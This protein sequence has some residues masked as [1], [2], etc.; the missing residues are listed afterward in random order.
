[1]A[2]PY[3]CGPSSTAPTSWSI[4]PP[5]SWAGTVRSIGGIIVDSGQV[6]LDR[7]VPAITQPQSRYHG[8]KFAETFG[9]LAYIVKDAR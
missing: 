6:R 1:M 3:L 9:N 8:M 7:Q 2:S 5:N 4:R